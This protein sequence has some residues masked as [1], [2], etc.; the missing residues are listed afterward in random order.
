MQVKKR[1]RK[2]SDFWTE[3]GL[4][5]GH[6]GEQTERLFKNLAS[7]FQRLKQLSHVSGASTELPMLRGSEDLFYAFEAYYL[8]YFP[9]GGSTL[10]GLVL[11][12]G[13]VVFFN[14]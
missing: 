11:T 2:T 5:V 6:S 7:D 8:L 4:E 9:H 13:S 10:P 14:K 1:C 12:E 3:V